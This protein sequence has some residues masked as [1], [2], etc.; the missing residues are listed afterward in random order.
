MVLHQMKEELKYVS[1]ESGELL[2]INPGIE[3]RPKLSVGNWDIAKLEVILLIN[4]DFY[5][6]CF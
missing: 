2:V 1:M 6:D 4:K 5:N 3:E